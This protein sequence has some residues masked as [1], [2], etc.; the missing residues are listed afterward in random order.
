MN[1]YFAALSVNGNEL[2]TVAARWNKN[3]DYI[4]EGFCR[5][6]SKGFAKG[7]VVDQS[8]A[9]NT[10][11][12]A[13]NKIR[14]KTGKKIRDVYLGVSSTSVDL[15]SST[16]I[17]LLSK[18][19]R[20]ITGNDLTKCVKIASTIRTPLDK[21]PLH[22]IVRGFSI[23]GDGHIADPLNLEGVKLSADVN[24]VT[25]N[26]SV[27]RNMSK[28]V[29]QAGF[30]SVGF[31][32]SGLAS[33]YRVL[34][35]DDLKTDAAVFDI[36]SDLTELMVFS[37]GRMI[38]CKVL[39]A[40]SGSVLTENG[41]IDTEAL[42]RLP[43]RVIALQ[44]WSKVERIVITGEGV[45]NPDLIE[46]VDELFT[47]PV[48]AASCIAKPF[49]DL[50]P[51]RAGYTGSLGILDHLQQEKKAERMGCN[52]LQRGYYRILSFIDRYF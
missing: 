51:D 38:G 10:V 5:T 22:R 52:I 48:K 35:E 8:L 37:K 39:S 16:G 15:V 18:Y 45:L 4:L 24:I 44:G 12:A 17:V 30:L 2:S 49:E 11:S 46:A 9:T 7:M 27:L 13:L 21:E 34:N 28:C 1:K 25:I 29:M 23:D 32:F 20:E 6:P 43:E 19:G 40:G 33:S 3:G 50:P 36:S 31:V 26:S 47:Q 41:K 42:D 14:E